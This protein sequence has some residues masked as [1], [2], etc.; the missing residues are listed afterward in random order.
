MLDMFAADCLYSVPPPQN[1]FSV[2]SLLQL[3]NNVEKSDEEEYAGESDDSKRKG[4]PRRN[5]TTFSSGQLRALEKVFERT[6]YPDAFVREELARR[7][8]LSEARVQVWFQNRRAKFRRN[9]RTLASQ[10][11][12]TRVSDSQTAEAR[13]VARPSTSPAATGLPTSAYSQLPIHSSCSLQQYCQPS[14][15]SS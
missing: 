5:R 13:L 1:R 2:T 8:G 14:F 15:P 7:V 6:H 9:E 10:R 4:K 11:Q 12:P 3:D